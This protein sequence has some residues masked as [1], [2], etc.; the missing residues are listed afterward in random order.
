VKV[1]RMWWGPAEVA[2]P[3]VEL[4]ILLISSSSGIVTEQPTSGVLTSP[5]YPELYSGPIE[6][7]QYIEVPEGNTIWIRFTDLQCDNHT[8]G[9]FFDREEIVRITKRDGEFDE[10]LNEMVNLMNWHSEF[11]STTNKVEVRFR[12]SEGRRA[13]SWRLEWGMVRP[14][15]NRKRSGVFTSLHFPE[16]YT[17]GFQSHKILIPHGTRVRFHFT[18]FNLQHYNHWVKIAQGS[19]GNLTP[20][21]SGTSVPK[22]VITKPWSS[23][24][25][26]LYVEFFVPSS[27]VYEGGWRLEWSEIGEDE[28]VEENEW[29]EADS[30]EDEG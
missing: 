18:S 23:G 30:D 28:E 7:D 26:T 11:L 10:S 17:T 8:G 15:E 13:A 19:V 5:N 29:N 9:Q 4:A 25:S 12:R 24:H 3:F 21:L 14:E 22:D 16:P 2:I 1:R 6:L 20:K 27:G